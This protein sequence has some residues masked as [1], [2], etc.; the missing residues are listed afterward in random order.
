M[1]QTSLP[2]P[3]EVLCGD[4]GGRLVVCA[5]RSTDL[6]AFGALG[7][8]VAAVVTTSAWRFV[9]SLRLRG[10]VVGSGHIVEFLGVDLE[11]V[12]LAC[13]SSSPGRPW[14]RGVELLWRRAC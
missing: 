12:M 3:G 13:A 1:V 10:G 11:Q 8:V 4:A 6:A 14:W 2:H 7:E 9:P 5:C